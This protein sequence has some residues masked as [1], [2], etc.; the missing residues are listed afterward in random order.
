MLD[1]Q[2]ILAKLEKERKFA[3]ESNMEIMAFGIG[4]AMKVI[5]NMKENGAE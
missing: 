3:V 4:Q 1:K 2:E 5:E